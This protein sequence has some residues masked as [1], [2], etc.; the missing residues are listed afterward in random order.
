MN[1]DQYIKNLNSRFR[2]GIAREH[3]YRGDLQSLIESLL[4]GVLATNE[5]ARIECGAPDY[6]LTRGGAP[7]AY[8]E[9][10][11]I[12]VDL[13]SNSLQ[14]QANRYKEALDNIVFTNYLQFDFYRS[15]EL[16]SRLE[17]GRVAHGAIVA[18]PETFPEFESTLLAFAANVSRT[19][20]SPVRLAQLMAAKARLMA[21]IIE[22]ALDTDDATQ[23]TSELKGQ[24][25]AFKN[26]LIQTISNKDFADIYSQTIAYGLF[27]ARYH[28]PTLPTFSREEAASLIPKSNPFLRRLFHYLAGP[29]IDSRL[30][31][32]VDDLVAIFLAVDVAAIM[33]SFGKSTRQTNPVIHFYETF[34]ASYDSDVRRA[35]GVWYTP[36]PIVGFIVR[37]V[38]EVLRT[39]FELKNGIADV[40]KTE[41]SR[42]VPNAKGKMIEHKELVHRVQV[43]DPATGTGTFLSEVVRFVH[44]TYFAS[45]RGIWPDYVRTDLVP[46]LNGFE[47][48]MT[49]YAMAHL[50][51][52]VLLASTGYKLDTS[53]D[54]LRIYLTNSLEEHHPETGTLF[55]GWLSAEA[56]EANHIKRDTPVMVVLGNPPY[57]GISKN[58]GKWITGLIEDYKYVDGCHFKEKKHWLGDDYVKFIRYGQHFVE[59]NG[60]GIV[61]YITPHGFLDNPTF[62]GMRWHLLETFDFIYTIDLHGNP[63]KGRTPNDGGK[64]ENVFE[65]TQGVAITIFIKTGQKAKKKMARV[66]HCEKL[67]SR[68]LKYSFLQSNSLASLPFVELDVRPPLYNF[69]PTCSEPASQYDSYFS[70]AEI[71]PLQSMGFVS[72]NDDLNISFEKIDAEQK[73]NS[74]LVQGEASWREATGRKKDA[75]DWTYATAKADAAAADRTS[76]F[77]KVAYRPF[78]VR[79]SLYTGNSRGLYASPQSNVMK[80]LVAEDNIALVF[81]KRG[82]N[83]EFNNYFVTQLPT[84]KNIISSLDNANVFPL[85]VTDSFGTRTPNI[86]E[87]AILL[88]TDAIGLPFSFSDPDPTESDERLSFGPTDVLDYVYGSVHSIQYQTAFRDRLKSDLPRI[89]PPVDREAFFEKG[90]FGRKV[91][92]AHLL[93]GIEPESGLADYPVAGSNVVSFVAYREE[94]VHI[95][96]TQH[97]SPVPIDLWNAYVG[98]Y[99]PLQKWLKDRKGRQLSYSDVTHYQRIANAIK[100]LSQLYQQPS[101]PGEES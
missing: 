57:S 81:V 24:L 53:S 6:V 5:P 90:R 46:R 31:W 16:V 37:A 95:N 55:A 9:A 72:A 88:F 13:Q 25:A 2:T 3:A 54:R 50:N 10:K 69:V 59:K 66:F 40:S 83:P 35:R 30:E 64:D 91:R 75:R 52:D 97:F 58:K 77:R 49:S 82:R 85:F 7:V 43:L 22:N 27:A 100:T 41:I 23:E 48:L 1:L 44:D 45:A 11:D 74:L 98:G 39:R 26:I 94:R 99:Q 79:Y 29:D 92:E 4:P 15:G 21:N 60:S 17:L 68:E 42:Q 20:R 89:P 8:V 70:V 38:D 78:D 86:S 28:D 47:L 14:E 33:G 101:R 56:N 62:R 87:R 80:N 84:D 67:G 96:D 73:I 65:I 76:Q 12:G 34:L 19:I 51:V 63:K 71:F 36:E 32:I 61:A 93:V 18:R